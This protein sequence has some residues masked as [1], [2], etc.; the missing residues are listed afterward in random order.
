MGQSA[1]FGR[2]KGR[3]ERSLLCKEGNARPRSARRKDRLQSQNRE[4][5]KEKQR[6]CPSGSINGRF[7]SYPVQTVKKG[8]WGNARIHRTTSDA[9]SRIHPGNR[10]DG[11]GRGQAIWRKQE[12]H[13][14][15]CLRSIAKIEFA[16]I[17]AGTCCAGKKQGGKAFKGWR[18]N[19]PQIQSRAGLSPHTGKIRRTSKTKLRITGA[20]FLA[21]RTV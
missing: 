4:E 6:I 2:R 19:T 16:A 13:P 8:E 11:T 15:G 20:F 21:P 14:Q 7:S 17:Q 12:H 18:S 9:G 1:W 3:A 10:R 5:N